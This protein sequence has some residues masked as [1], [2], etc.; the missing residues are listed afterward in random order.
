LT[1]RVWDL[2]TTGIEATDAVVEV[3]FVDVGDRKAG[4]VHSWLTDPGIPIPP[5][6][7]AIHHIIDDDVAGEPDF[8]TRVRSLGNDAVHGHAAH[9]AAFERMHLTP[10]LIGAAPW[11]CTYK[12]AL[13]VWPEAPGQ[14]NQALRYWLNLP[15]ANRDYCN[16]V[17]RAGPDALVT[18]HLLVMLGEKASSREMVR[19]S[20]EPALLPKM[21]FGKHKGE[22]WSALPDDYLSWILKENDM[23][24][25]V[26][27]G[28]GREWRRR[29][30]DEVAA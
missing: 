9:N 6:A 1:I 27:F 17:H 18:A 11:I 5:L 14:S 26:K 12:C 24:E 10:A 22:A 29:Y 4:K 2:E 28:A 3:A 7:S 19:W 21:P 20:A 30:P 25:A 23:D 8:A 16:Q 15:I 13:R